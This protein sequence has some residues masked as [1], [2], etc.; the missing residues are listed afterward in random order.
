MLADRNIAQLFPERFYSEA[1]RGKYRDPES[2]TRKSF[3]VFWNSMG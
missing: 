1:T 2:N 3:Q